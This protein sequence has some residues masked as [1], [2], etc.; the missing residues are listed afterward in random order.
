MENGG[1]LFLL[2][3]ALGFAQLAEPVRFR[4]AWEQAVAR[5]A[6]LAGL[7]AAAYAATATEN[8]NHDTAARR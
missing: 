6:R 5:E 1:G 3:D 4:V 7:H 8:G 2:A